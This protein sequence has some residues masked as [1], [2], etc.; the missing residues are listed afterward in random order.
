MVCGAIVGIDEE[1]TMKDCF[2]F[3]SGFGESIFLSFS[4]VSNAGGSTVTVRRLAGCR[5]LA[6]ACFEGERSGPSCFC[7]CSP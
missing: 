5:K 6:A 3:V 2:D 7:G 4:Y 1:L